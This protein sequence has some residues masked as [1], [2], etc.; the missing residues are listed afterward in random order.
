V[1]PPLV[2]L[3]VTLMLAGVPTGLPL[4]R[5]VAVRRYAVPF[6]SCVKVYP[7]LKLTTSVLQVPTPD[8][9]EPSRV[10]RTPFS[11]VPFPV[12]LQ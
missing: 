9:S 6:L 3:G 4:R 2:A 5:G 1:F 11:V 12:A 7:P 8:V 10:S